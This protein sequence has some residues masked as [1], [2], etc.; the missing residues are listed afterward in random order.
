M[1]VF[2]QP[3][4]LPYLLLLWWHTK[5]DVLLMVA[6]T[7]PCNNLHRSST[8]LSYFTTEEINH[9]IIMSCNIFQN[10]TFSISALLPQY[11]AHNNNHVKNET[12]S[13]YT[14][15][16]LPWSVTL[17]SNKLKSDQIEDHWSQGFKNALRNGFS[18]L[19]H[20]QKRR[21][22]SISEKTG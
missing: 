17:T 11:S 10:S 16:K 13:V 21:Q 18:I 4:F 8:A 3:T 1:T 22:N 5:Y 9:Q 19:S 12:L 7:V 15:D 20:W 14:F 2:T 6:P